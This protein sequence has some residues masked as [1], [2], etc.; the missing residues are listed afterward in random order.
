IEKLGDFD[1][2]NEKINTELRSLRV[3]S[4]SSDP[5]L[6]VDGDFVTVNSWQDFIDAASNTSVGKIIIGVDLKAANNRVSFQ[7]NKVV[8]FNGHSIDMSSRYLNTNNYQINFV[9]ASINSTGSAMLRATS[10][11]EIIFSGIGSLT[12]SIL[13]TSNIYTNLSFTNA[14]YVTQNTSA[15]PTIR[16]RGSSGGD[17]SIKDS[18]VT[19]SSRGF[20]YSSTSDGLT[21]NINIDNSTVKSTYPSGTSNYFIS[22]SGTYTQTGMTFKMTNNSNVNVDKTNQGDFNAPVYLFGKNTKIMLSSNSK[23][24][25]NNPNGS[26]ITESGVGSTFDVSDEGTELNAS[27]SGASTNN[28]AVIRFAWTGEMTFDIKNHAKVS[29][30]QNG[31]LNT[32]GIRMY[33]GG[34]NISVSNGAEFNCINNSTSGSPGVGDSDGQ[35][36]YYAG[37]GNSNS[38]KLDGTDSQVLISA[39]NGP[40][41]SSST[42]IDMTAGNGT[43]FVARGYYPGNAIFYSSNILNFNM[44]VP[45]YF[46]FMN[47]AS[48]GTGEGG[49]LFNCANTSQFSHGNIPLSVWLSTSNVQG[50]PTKSWNYVNA[51]YSGVN[52]TKFTTTSS[53]ASFR[54]FLGSNLGLSK[55]GRMTANTSPAQVKNAPDQPTNADS[56]VWVPTLMPAENNAYR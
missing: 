16:F 3:Q 33:G 1:L 26:A 27:R 43:S 38:F 31:T 9:D 45:R 8:V 17:L 39:N 35:G 15:N 54:E 22:T 30:N 32:Y 12:G 11:A 23:F 21:K 24:T 55:L 13:N 7:N 29:I 42:R 49:T 36:I 5:V 40:A 34:N 4:K 52:F 53:D 44:E 6:N 56:Y 48:S 18:T 14:N 37:G 51:T 46:D 47:T 28:N 25:V 41:I 50:S 19:D 10:N 2:K 20:Y